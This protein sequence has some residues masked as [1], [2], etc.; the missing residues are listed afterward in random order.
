[1]FY[2]IFWVLA[3]VS[4]KNMGISFTIIC[5]FVTIHG[6]WN[7]LFVKFEVGWLKMHII[8]G[9][10]TCVCAGVLNVSCTIFIGAR[11]LAKKS[12]G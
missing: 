11:S 4:Y 6:S 8:N 5:P 3:V 7:R 10:L 9:Y 12:C 2:L 1:M